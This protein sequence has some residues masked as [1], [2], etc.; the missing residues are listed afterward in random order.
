MEFEFELYHNILFLSLN[1]KKCHALKDAFFRDQL[2]KIKK[3]HYIFQPLYDNDFEKP[4]TPKRKY[5]VSLIENEA[6]KYLNTI[7]TELNKALSLNEKKYLFDSFYKIINL[8]FREIQTI[9]TKEGYSY[10]K[11]KEG[12]E[13]ENLEDEV[14]IIQYLK[15]ELIRIYLEITEKFSDLKTNDIYNEGEIYKVYFKEK[16]ASPSLFHQQYK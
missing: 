2:L 9:C 6:I 4:L 14:Y 10:N 15:T 16:S 11:L 5:Y 1:P 7:N 12:I 8:K 3:E 13:N